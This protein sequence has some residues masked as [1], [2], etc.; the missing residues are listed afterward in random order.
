VISTLELLAS[1]VIFAAGVDA[2]EAVD[3]AGGTRR[4]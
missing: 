3:V 1:L 4:C 2:F